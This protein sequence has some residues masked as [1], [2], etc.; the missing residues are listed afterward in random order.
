M[1]L[2]WTPKVRE[3]VSRP[4][5][6]FF[7]LLPD[8]MDSFDCDYHARNLVSHALKLL[9]KRYIYLEIVSNSRKGGRV[10]HGK[11]HFWITALTFLGATRVTLIGSARRSDRRSLSFEPKLTAKRY[12]SSL[13]QPIFETWYVCGHLIGK[14]LR[15]ENSCR[16][17]NLCSMHQ[18]L[19][20]FG[21]VVV[22]LLTDGT[23]KRNGKQ[24]HPSHRYSPGMMS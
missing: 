15:R 22:V 18:D 4:R 8:H 13:A 20:D 17:R 2:F 16:L 3:G 19:N 12:I 9:G 14:R 21:Y 24:R 6:S 23:Q 10:W 1:R 5:P 7:R 11:Q